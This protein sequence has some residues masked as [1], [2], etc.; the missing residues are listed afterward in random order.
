MKR[1]LT[2]ELIGFMNLFDQITRVRP[3]DCF[4]DDHETLVFTVDYPFLGKAIG[5]N[6]ANVH[7]LE[8]AFKRKIKIIG[9]SPDVVGF[10]KN[11]IYPLTVL[12]IVLD[13]EMLVLGGADTKTK[14]LLI[15]RNAHNLRNTEK[16]IQ[17]YFPIKEVKVV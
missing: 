9:Y 15:G 14:S 12:E 13:G 6:A 17:R 7:G 11:V 1:K 16:I 3:K 10:T 4:V 2:L 5:K 8:Q